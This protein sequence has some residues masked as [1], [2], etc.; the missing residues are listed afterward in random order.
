[1]SGEGAVCCLLPQQPPLLYSPLGL[2]RQACHV[3]PCSVRKSAGRRGALPGQVWGVPPPTARLCGGARAA[4]STR[5][6][7]AACPIRSPIRRGTARRTQAAAHDGSDHV[8]VS[9]SHDFSPGLPGRLRFGS[10]P[11]WARESSAENFAGWRSRT[12]VRTARIVVL[13]LVTLTTGIQ[14]TVSLY[15]TFYK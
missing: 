15:G 9:S 5:E 8:I 10:G 12:V 2:P 11:G 3:T 13:D 1:M 4:A 6:T 14:Y 7:A